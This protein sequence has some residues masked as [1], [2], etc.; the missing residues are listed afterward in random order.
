MMKLRYGNQ[1]G[2]RAGSIWRLLFVFA[3]MLW[4]RRYRIQNGA[5]L[6]ADEIKGKVKERNNY[7]KLEKEN[8]LL[9]CQITEHRTLDDPLA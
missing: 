9:E 5:D 7:E 6:D 8:K 2:T 4:L 1:F 3:L